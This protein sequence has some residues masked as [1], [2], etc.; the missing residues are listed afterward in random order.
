M[1]EYI[2]DSFESV[3]GSKLTNTAVCFVE[4]FA[5][6]G[7]SSGLLSGRMFYDF[8]KKYF[9][10][11]LSGFPCVLV[12][13][14]IMDTYGVS[15]A[16]CLQNLLCYVIGSGLLSAY[17][18]VEIK[19]R[20]EQRYLIAF[21]NI[22][23]LGSCFL[24][25]GIEGV[26][27]WIH[28]GPL[29]LNVGFISIPVLLIVIYKMADHQNSN[30]SNIL[31]LVIAAILCLQPDASMLSAFSIALV[32]FYYTNNKNGFW[33]Y[34]WILLLSLSCISWLNLDNLEPVPYVEDILMLAVQQS[35]IYLLGCVISLVI[36][37]IPFFKR[38]L[39]A[40]DKR[41]SVS[42]GLF[43]L[44]LILSTL[45]GNFPVP[46]IGYG[47]S[48]IVGYLLSVSYVEKKR[49]HDRSCCWSLF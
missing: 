36:M 23:L 7:M 48:P 17:L 44:V 16:I 37:L 14:I 11:F 25:E 5:H 12:G 34:S 18:S 24:F 21:F 30:A 6:G 1:E 38:D 32:P 42:L 43:F 8:M 35:I 31:I 22:V 9:I 3:T 46:L 45:L 10:P 49:S 39:S 27:R 19:F 13:T 47:I 33:K 2:K 40:H 28:I 29:A 20:P 41:I 26:H 15:L 4:A